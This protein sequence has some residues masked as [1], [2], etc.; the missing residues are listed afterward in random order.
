MGL[1]WD[2]NIVDMMSCEKALYK[3]C[4]CVLL[5]W[6]EGFPNSLIMG[7]VH[8]RNP[9]VTDHLLGIWSLGGGAVSRKNSFGH[10]SLIF[11]RKIRGAGLP[12]PPP[13]SP[14]S[15]QLVV[16]SFFSQSGWIQGHLIKKRPEIFKF[17]ALE[18]SECHFQY[19]GSANC[20][21]LLIL[22]SVCNIWENV[23]IVWRGSEVVTLY[24]VL[25]T[26]SPFWSI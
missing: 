11:G 17:Y 23:K 3:L 15:T 13:P 24:S 18:W 19:N 14:G 20:I 8:C 22:A 26:Y 9:H 4:G 1:V 16:E 7:R 12:L 5:L 6:W 21:I 25:M 2:T 10:L